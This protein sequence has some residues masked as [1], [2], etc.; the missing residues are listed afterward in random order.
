MEVGRRNPAI[1]HAP[2]YFRLM[3]SLRKL[4]VIRRYNRPY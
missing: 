4:G 3:N 1:G 2:S